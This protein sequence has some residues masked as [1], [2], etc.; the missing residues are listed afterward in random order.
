[1]QKYCK[2]FKSPKEGNT[3]FQVTQKLLNSAYAKARK[4]KKKGMIVIAIPA[5]DK[6]NYVLECVL[7]KEVI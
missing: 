7:T 3:S 2:T 4:A 1:M 5:D 6:H